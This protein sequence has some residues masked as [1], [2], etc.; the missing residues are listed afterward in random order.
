MKRAEPQQVNT[1][2]AQAY[3]IT[4]DL[5]DPDGRNYIVD[6]FACDHKL[7]EVYSESTKSEAEK[8]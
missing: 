7:A 8:Q 3:K 5:L 6:G 1:P 4:N 2:P